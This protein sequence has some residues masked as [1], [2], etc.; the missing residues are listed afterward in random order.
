M[1]KILG[2]SG[3]IIITISVLAFRGQKDCPAEGKPNPKKGKNAVLKPR[4]KELNRHKNRE[5]LPQSSDFDNNVSIQGMYDSK[6]DSIY[7]ENKAANLIGYVFRAVTTGMESCNCYTEDKSKYSVNV[8][9]SKD[10]ITKQTKTSECI[11][12]VVT[13]YSIS[14][15]KDWTSDNINDKLVGKRVKVSGWLIF[16]YLKSNES[17]ETNSNGTQL[18]R[19]TIWGICPLTNITALE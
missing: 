10:P 8:Y 14:L 6:D 9:I 4:E 3:I 11:V 5:S 17:V 1:K 16:D 7:N 13:P 19:R 15:N 12:A 2:L 18:D